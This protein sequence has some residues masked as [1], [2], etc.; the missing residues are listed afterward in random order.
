MVSKCSLWIKLLRVSTTSTL[1]RR[2]LPLL[3]RLEAS[4][5]APQVPTSD[6]LN[7]TGNTPAR[8][9]RSMTA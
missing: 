5:T 9:V 8:S 2:A 4:Q 7:D 3:S 6:Q 1:P